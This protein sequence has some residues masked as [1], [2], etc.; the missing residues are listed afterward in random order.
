MWIVEGETGDPLAF[1]YQVA[2][3]VVIDTIRSDRIDHDSFEDSPKIANTHI[4]AGPCEE[5]GPPGLFR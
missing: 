3:I 4:A 2:R 1:D 5:T